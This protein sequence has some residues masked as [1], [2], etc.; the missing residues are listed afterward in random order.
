M[1]DPAATHTDLC[2][3]DRP[4]AKPVVDIAVRIQQRV[5]DMIV[6]DATAMLSL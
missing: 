4:T 2:R 3:T 1:L 6:T 5:I